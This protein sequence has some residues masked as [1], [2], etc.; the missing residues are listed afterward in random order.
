MKS[1]SQ[2]SNSVVLERTL[3]FA[4]NTA[5]NPQ[6]HLWVTDLYGVKRNTTGAADLT[7]RYGVRLHKHSSSVTD[8]GRA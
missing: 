8:G 2:S 3:P 1:V 5:W 6:V 4:V 7:I